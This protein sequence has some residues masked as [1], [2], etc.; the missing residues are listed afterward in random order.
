MAYRYV[1]LVR[2]I[3]HVP[4]Q[5]MSVRISTNTS[6]L[7]CVPV[8]WS[9]AAQLAGAIAGVAPISYSWPRPVYKC[10]S[11]EPSPQKLRVHL[12]KTSSEATKVKAYPHASINLE[13]IGIVQL[14]KKMF[15]LLYFIGDRCKVNTLS[16]VSWPTRRPG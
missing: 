5:I 9:S 2:C 3:V 12:R 1:H 7:C 16:R 15:C 14:I 10:K 11:A 4:D 13:F 6:A 8:S